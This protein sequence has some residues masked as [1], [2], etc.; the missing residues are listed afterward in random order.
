MDRRAGRLDG[1][2][3]QLARGDGAEA[4]A[5]RRP[6]IWFGG[7]H[8]AALRR[9]VAHADGFFGAGSQTTAAFAEQMGVVREALDAAGRDPSTF[10]IAKR[11]YLTVDDDVERAPERPRRRC[12]GS[13]ASSACRTSPRWRCTGPPDAVAAGLREVIDAGAELV[14]LNPMFDD[15]EQIE[16]LSAEVL[17][18]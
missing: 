3:W 1:R 10:R 12:T 14:V 16:R 18:R 15:A 2:F 4:G 17:P 5:G 9:A 6:P 7:A 13:T 11:V 8:P